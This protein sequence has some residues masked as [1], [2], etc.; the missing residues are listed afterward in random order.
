MLHAYFQPGAEPLPSIADDTGLIQPVLYE[1]PLMPEFRAMRLAD[2]NWLLGATV[3][4]VRRAINTLGRPAEFDGCCCCRSR[5]VVYTC[6]CALPGVKDS[7]EACRVLHLLLL[8]C[9]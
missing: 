8:A 7:R 9:L 1:W 5:A 3:Q 2:Y 6:I 4:Q